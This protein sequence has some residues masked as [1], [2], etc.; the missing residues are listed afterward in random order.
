MSLTIVDIFI[1]NIMF[2]MSHIDSRQ[3]VALG[4]VYLVLKYFH[5]LKDKDKQL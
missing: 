1:C 5:V 4:V 3:M 2:A